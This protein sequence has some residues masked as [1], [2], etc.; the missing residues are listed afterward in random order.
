[1]FSV[2][3]HFKDFNFSLRQDSYFGLYN[4]HKWSK[5]SLVLW[6]FLVALSCIVSN[7]VSTRAYKVLYQAE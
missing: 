5:W 6:I 7:V 4:D 3:A 1:M 2:V